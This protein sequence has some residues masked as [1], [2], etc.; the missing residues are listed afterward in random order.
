MEDIFSEH[1]M[2]KLFLPNRIV[3][4]PMARAG[5]EGIPSSAMATYYA[6]RASA[7]LIITEATNISDEA[8]G[9]WQSPGIYTDQPVTGWKQVTNAMHAKG[10]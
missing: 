2:G 8:F 9:W 3:M 5:L 1:S 4:A 7:G 10:G 6:Q